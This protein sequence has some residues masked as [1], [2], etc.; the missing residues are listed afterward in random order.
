M[1]VSEVLVLEYAVPLEVRC[2][3]HSELW[4]AILE[5]GGGVVGSMCDSPI[6]AFMFCSRCLH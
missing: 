1:P 6:S 2:G 3:Y 5:E 4:I